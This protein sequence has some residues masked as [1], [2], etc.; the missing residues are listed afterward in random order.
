MTSRPTFAIKKALI[1]L[2][3]LTVF[4]AIAAE[5][6][7]ARIEKLI[8]ENLRQPDTLVTIETENIAGALD[9]CDAPKAFLPYSVSANGG[10]TTVGF[11]CEDG[12]APRYIPVTFKVSGAY[13][14]P[15]QD[16]PRG[17]IISAT[18]LT[19]QSGDLSR[20]PRN[21]VRLGDTLLGFQSNRVL[22]AG[23][24]IQKTALQAVFAVKRNET[25]DV[26]ASGPGFAIKR[27]GT[28]MDNGAVNEVIRVK[29]KGGDII[30]ATVTGRQQLK[31]DI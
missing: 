3:G 17:A 25:V 9:G 2:A 4:P 21:V 15:A 22:K 1:L 7:G 14:V 18:M 8:A 24:P 27:E 12:Q 23:A 30:R 10:R 31:I 5:D 26:I 16:I 6:P 11:H 29:V 20:L 28:A 13:W 19:E